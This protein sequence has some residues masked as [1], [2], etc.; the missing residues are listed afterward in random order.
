MV[1]LVDHVIEESKCLSVYVCYALLGEFCRALKLFHFNWRTLKV[2]RK[3]TE[4]TDL[5]Q[6]NPLCRYIHYHFNVS[7]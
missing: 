1:S 6:L 5:S 3:G 4:T 7:I 2:T